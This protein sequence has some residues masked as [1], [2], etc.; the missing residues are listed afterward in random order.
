MKLG[1]VQ[2]IQLDPECLGIFIIMNHAVIWWYF[3]V[4]KLNDVL[5]VNRGA[6]P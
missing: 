4:P 3:S 1:T 5:T 2:G 6:K